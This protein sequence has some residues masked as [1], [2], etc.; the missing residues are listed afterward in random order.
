[1]TILSK[2]ELSKEP[3]ML[4]RDENDEAQAKKTGKLN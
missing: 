3:Y 2:V 4:E 1:V